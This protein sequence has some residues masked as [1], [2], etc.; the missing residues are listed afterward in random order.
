MPLEEEFHSVSLDAIQPAVWKALW[1]VYNSSRQK[2]VV[3][4]IAASGD[5]VSIGCE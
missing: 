3:V 4:I 5:T 1:M 2:M